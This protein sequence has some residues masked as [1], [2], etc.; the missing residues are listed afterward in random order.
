MGSAIRVIEWQRA[1]PQSPRVIV[2]GE[3]PRNR[4]V[5]IVFDCSGSMGERLPDGRTRLEA[6]REALY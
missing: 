3:I 2:R 6:G 5:A 1:A 4:A